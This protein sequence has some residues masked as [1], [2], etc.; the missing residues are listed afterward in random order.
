MTEVELAQ[1]CAETMWNEDKASH[2]LGIEIQVTA[3]GVLLGQYSQ[4]ARRIGGLVSRPFGWQWNSD[5]AGLK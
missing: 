5:L 2:A 4:S 3:V 1:R